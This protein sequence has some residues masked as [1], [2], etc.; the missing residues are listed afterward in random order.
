MKCDSLEITDVWN[1]LE[2]SP[3]GRLLPDKNRGIRLSTIK[4]VKFEVELWKKTSD[5][6]HLV[7]SAEDLVL[8][9][10][11][12]H[13]NYKFAR[14]SKNVNDRIVN[15]RDN[16]TPSIPTPES[17]DVS[18][19]QSLFGTDSCNPVSERIIGG[20]QVPD[21][22][23]QPWQVFLHLCGEGCD[24]GCFMC[25]GTLL[26][27]RWILTA[28]HCLQSSCSKV[29]TN[30]KVRFGSEKMP[31][32]LKAAGDE[33]IDKIVLNSDYIPNL[34]END[35]AL[36]R[37]ARPV[38]F[39]DQIQPACLP[40][41]AKNLYNAFRNVQIAHLFSAKNNVSPILKEGKVQI[42]SS[43][44]RKCRKG[45]GLPANNLIPSTK[46]CAYA[47]GVDACQGDSGGPLLIE[48]NGRCA[49]AGI[50]SY[51]I[52]C[53]KK[54]FAGV[55][56]RVNQ[57]LPF[58]RETIQPEGCNGA[59]SST[60][61]PGSNG[62]NG[63]VCDL[64]CSNVNDL[65]E[66]GLYKIQG[67]LA[68]CDKGFCTA[69]EETDL[70]EALDNP[71]KG[72]LASDPIKDCHKPCNLSFYFKE[73]LDNVKYEEY[74][75]LNLY[76]LDVTCNQ[77]GDCCAAD[78]PPHANLCLRAALCYAGGQLLGLSFCG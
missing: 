4:M 5:L 10:D 6:A 40:Q 77:S 36:I 57:F 24:K 67:I 75:T 60:S 19:G 47:L 38:K 32:N 29:R 70:C 34:I 46:M 45:S 27:H 21:A 39:S 51:G 62:A 20:I 56:T 58:I 35:I 2:Q 11:K 74:V 53:A 22:A 12:I 8:E 41:N 48:E 76:G 73:Y 15:V 72:N 78:N 28:M 1:W 71:C 66:P 7:D 68:H 25:G 44:D 55:Y 49:V 13:I 50:V 14:L 16:N 69:T 23:R 26:N 37:L 63:E 3:L 9:H 43:R 59:S 31:N 52:D 42:L 54:N 64:T 18:C 30:I 17:C 33:E 61:K 65:E